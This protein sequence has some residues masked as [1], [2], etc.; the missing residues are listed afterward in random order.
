MHFFFK[1]Q[2]NKQTKQ[3]SNATESFPQLRKLLKYLIPIWT[4][5]LEA[6][7]KTKQNKTTNFSQVVEQI[8]LLRQDIALV[9]AVT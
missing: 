7:G 9:V 5:F 2:T 4:D 8:K 6:L 1:K 3:E